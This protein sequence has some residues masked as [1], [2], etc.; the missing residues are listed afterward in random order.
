MKGAIRIAAILM[1]MAVPAAGDAGED[2]RSKYAGM[3]SREIKT[4]SADDLEQ[5][6]A[7]RGWGLSLVAELN[8]V[9]GPKHLLDMREEIG[10]SAGQV[11]AIEA[12]FESMRSAAIPLG[13]ELIRLERQ[14]EASFA[15]GTID[16]QRLRDQLDAIARTR[17]DLRYVHL[18]AHLQTP[19]LLTGTQIRSYMRLRGY[20]TGDPC[21]SVPEGHDP[22]MWRKHNHCDA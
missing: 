3:E 6:R 15:D 10:L 5:L 7:G 1:L 11:T 13:H 8:G 16:N 4:L 21:R 9:P 17:R 12:I 20:D 19:A 22:E 14:L 2:H 18:S